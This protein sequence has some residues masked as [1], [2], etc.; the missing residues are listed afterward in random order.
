M[1]GNQKRRPHP[2]KEEKLTPLSFTTI[3]P[4]A[5]RYIQFK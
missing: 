5:T 1:D 2:S 3:R 4:S